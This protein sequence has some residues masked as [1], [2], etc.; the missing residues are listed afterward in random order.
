MVD[1]VM[2]TI[3]SCCQGLS[4]EATCVV[5]E[6]FDCDG[7]PFNFVIDLSAIGQICAVYRLEMVSDILIPIYVLVTRIPSLL[8]SANEYFLWKMISIY[9]ILPILEFRESS[10]ATVF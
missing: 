6:M 4:T 10:I 1:D 5:E 9:V 3:L 8:S 7:S 2:H